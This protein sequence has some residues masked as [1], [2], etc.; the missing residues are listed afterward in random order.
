M[1][2]RIA[3][4]EIMDKSELARNYRIERSVIDRYGEG[5]RRP[6]TRFMCRPEAEYWFEQC[7]QNGKDTHHFYLVRKSQVINWVEEDGWGLM[8][9]WAPPP[10][11]QVGFGKHKKQCRVGDLIRPFTGKHPWIR[12]EAFE[13]H[14]RKVKPTRSN[15]RGEGAYRVMLRLAD[16]QI[17][18]P[19]SVVRVMSLSDNPLAPNPRPGSN[20]P[21]LTN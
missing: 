18:P 16:G 4:C 3:P 14:R 19:S 17:I 1:G 7:L 11:M 2:W 15:P 8:P 9:K 6:F 12:I 21:D 20:M 5:P 13:R 10:V